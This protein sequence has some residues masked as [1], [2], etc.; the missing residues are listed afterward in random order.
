MTTSKKATVKKS[1]AKKVVAAVKKAV[2]RVT[3]PRAPKAKFVATAEVNDQV[4]VGKGETVFEAFSALQV[5]PF[6]FKTRMT[7][8][9]ES[10]KKQTEQIFFALQFRRFTNNKVSREIWAKR[11]ESKLN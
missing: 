6:L 3:Q 9:L 10:G 5:P 8:R 11:M 7:L 1:R 4:F 2:K